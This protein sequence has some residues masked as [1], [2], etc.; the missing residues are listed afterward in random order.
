M[1][2]G[3]LNDGVGNDL[4]AL[5]IVWRRRGCLAQFIPSVDERSIYHA[6]ASW[7]EKNETKLVTPTR[8]DVPRPERYIRLPV[9]SAGEGNDR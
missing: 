8:S 5:S 9:Q 4:D 3:G 7:Q 2:S 1:E 6:G